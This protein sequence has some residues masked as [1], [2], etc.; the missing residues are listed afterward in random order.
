M[1]LWEHYPLL[2]NNFL[3]HWSLMAKLKVLMFI[4]VQAREWFSWMC[5]SACEV[6]NGLKDMVW[7]GVWGGVWVDCRE[8]W[9]HW[10]GRVEC[11]KKLRHIPALHVVVC[12]SWY[13]CSMF[14]S[15]QRWVCVNVCVRARVYVCV[16]VCVIVPSSP[17]TLLA[18]S[19]SG[20]VLP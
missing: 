11:C 7:G 18:R 2:I 1:G 6:G 14:T 16:Y 5:A 12:L 3:L 19:R 17:F 15:T 4:C 9:G 10:V 20:Q 13:G 8:S